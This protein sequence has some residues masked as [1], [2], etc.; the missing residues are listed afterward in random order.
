MER[1]NYLLFCFTA[2]QYRETCENTRMKN[3]RKMCEPEVFL[4]H[5]QNMLCDDKIDKYINK[6]FL[7]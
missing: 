5:I 7:D 6:Y 3:S 2:S 1:I 4:R